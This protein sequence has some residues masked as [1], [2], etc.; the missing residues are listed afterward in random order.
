MKLTEPGKGKPKAEAKA[1]RLKEWKKPSKKADQDALR[2]Q[3]IKDWEGKNGSR[4][5]G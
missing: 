2:Q 1:A 3:R 5:Q 4:I